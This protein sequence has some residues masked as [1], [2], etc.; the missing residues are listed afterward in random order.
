MSISTNGQICFGVIVDELP[1]EDED[2]ES[3]WLDVQGYEPSFKLYESGEYV[4][5]V[6]PPDDK[7]EEYFAHKFDFQER[8]PLPVVLINYCSGDCPMYI[9]A[10]PSSVRSAHRGYPEPFDPVELKVEQ[11]EVDKLLQFCDDHGIERGWP[12]WWLSSYWG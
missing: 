3:W 5:G 4:D 6:K 11:N 10:V 2:I 12:R 8:H 7:I 1:W 9:L